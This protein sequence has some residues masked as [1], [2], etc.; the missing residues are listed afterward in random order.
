[1]GDP[2]QDIEESV[3][4]PK[5]A[6]S[7][8][9]QS[10]QKRRHQIVA[11]A[12][13]LILKSKSTDFSMNDL[14]HEADISMKTTYNLIGSKSKVLY[15]LLSSALDKVDTQAL[16]LVDKTDVNSIVYMAET[17]IAVFTGLPE[18][19]R[20]LLRYL[21]GTPNSTERPIF[22]ARAYQFWLRGLTHFEKAAPHGLNVRT[23]A[24]H[25]HTYFAGALDL[26]VQEEIDAEDFRR[27]LRCAAAIVLMPY[28]ERDQHPKLQAHVDLFQGSA[29]SYGDALADVIIST[30]KLM[31]P[32]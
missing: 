2:V 14:A 30:E 9:E 29:A 19:Y 25:L 27:H 32:D 28:V 3:E 8:R 4:P 1:M 20:P 13:R 15:I 21:L 6:G 18:F 12:E 23:I 16:G 24:L 26:W 7:T 17:P 10:K 11:A 22:M 31:S 5:R